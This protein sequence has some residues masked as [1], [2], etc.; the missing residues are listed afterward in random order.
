M[1][2]VGTASPKISDLLDSEDLNSE[3]IGGK[4][5][6]NIKI[7]C[8]SFPSCRISSLTA[9]VNDLKKCGGCK[10]V[11][12]CGAEHQ[13]LHWKTHKIDCKK[14]ALEATTKT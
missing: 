8:C 13:K 14:W 5:N 11:Q 2:S 3:A 12:Y 7:D 1:C 6:H 4:Y 10:R 9:A